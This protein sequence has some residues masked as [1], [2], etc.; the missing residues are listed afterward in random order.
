MEKWANLNEV[1]AYKDKH[2]VTQYSAKTSL[3]A[4]YSNLPDR[5]YA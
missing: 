4:L 2:P 1:V 3:R 5:F